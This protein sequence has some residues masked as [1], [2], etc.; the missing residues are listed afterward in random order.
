MNLWQYTSRLMKM[1]H[2][3]N[4]LK[5]LWKIMRN[6]NNLIFQKI[7]SLEYF[8]SQ[9]KIPFSHG[10]TNKFYMAINQ[11]ILPILQKYF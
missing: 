9:N 11:E 8:L 5:A 2:H 7:T 3:H 6:W 10:F 4:F 1:G